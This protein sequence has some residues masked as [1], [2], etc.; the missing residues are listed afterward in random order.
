MSHMGEIGKQEL[1]VVP[2]PTVRRIHEMLDAG[3]AE[4][5]S[6]I[7]SAKGGTGKTTALETWRAKFEPGET[8]ALTV[9]AGEGGW[10]DVARAVCSA[11]RVSCNSSAPP[12]WRRKLATE[13]EIAWPRKGFVTL[14]EGQNATPQ[15]VEWLC[16]ALHDAGL[17]FALVGDE[18]LP[19]RLKELVE[20]RRNGRSLPPLILRGAER[21]DVRALADAAGLRDPKALAVLNR[22]AEHGSGLRDVVAVLE[23]AAVAAGGAAMSQ[24]HVTWAIRECGLSFNTL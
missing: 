13:I 12:E 18:R 22:V 3:L 20:T 10:K 1:G 14:D 2:T 8:V 24:E 9:A 11:F 7:V 15:A 16:T 6:V 21:G 19:V 5:R 17:P 23:T 4:G